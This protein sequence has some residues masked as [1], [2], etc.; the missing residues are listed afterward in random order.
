[1]F[2]IH[3]TVYQ[4]ALFWLVGFHIFDFSSNHP[5]VNKMTYNVFQMVFYQPVF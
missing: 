1:M 3:A 5:M 4:V 2:N